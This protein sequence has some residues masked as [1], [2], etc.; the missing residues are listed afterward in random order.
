MLRINQR[1][2]EEK[3]R[4]RSAVPLLTH[5]RALLTGEQTAAHDNT[6]ALMKV[7]HAPDMHTKLFLSLFFPLGLLLSNSHIML[8]DIQNAI[9]SLNG[10][11][12]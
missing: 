12:T 8:Y 6:Q 1:R 10:S 3:E 4:L 2:A 5:Y 9:G 11:L 7:M